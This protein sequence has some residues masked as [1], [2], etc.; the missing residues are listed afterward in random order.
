MAVVSFVQASF[1]TSNLPLQTVARAAESPVF[2]QSIEQNKRS[3]MLPVLP[4]AVEQAGRQDPQ[5]GFVR[6]T[7][8]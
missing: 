8:T 6:L 7:A 5:L 4:K 1:K 2:Y 3:M